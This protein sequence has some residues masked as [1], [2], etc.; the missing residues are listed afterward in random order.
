MIP[1][2]SCRQQEEDEKI[3]MIRVKVPVKTGMQKNS[4]NAYK[5]PDS[6]TS[7]DTIIV[8]GDITLS[9]PPPKDRDQWK[10]KN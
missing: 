3:E 9:D 2:C 6:E 10:I 5:L 1:F 4:D 7:R 8:G